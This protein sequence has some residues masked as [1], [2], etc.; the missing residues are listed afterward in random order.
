MGNVENA[1]E[2]LKKY[3]QEHVIEIMNSFTE[4]EKEAISEQILDMNFDTIKSLYDE[5]S[6]DDS[7]FGNNIEPIH[8]LRK[9]KISEEELEKITNLGEDIIKSGKFAVATM[10]GGQGTRLGYNHPKGTFKIDVEPSPKYLFEI[11]CD[12]LKRANK[13]YGVIIPWYIMTS[14]DNNDEIIEFFEEQ[15]YFGYPKESIKFFKQGQMPL[16]SEDGKLLVGENKLI[17]E[18]S[19]G[20]GGIFS[21]MAK[22]GC[23]ADMEKKGVKWL[24]IGSIDNVLLKMADPC[25]IGLA[26]ERG[27]KIATKSVVKNSPTERVGVICKQDGKVGVMEYSEIPKEYSEAVDEDGELVYGESHIMCNLFNMDI[28]KELADKKLAYHKAH[29][30]NSFIDK[31]GN[32]IKPEEPNSY[33]FEMF[34]FDSF[35]YVN[36]IAILRGKR[37]VDFAP[38]KNK[39]GNDS[40]ETARELYNNYWK[41]VRGE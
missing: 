3:N 23:L 31:N 5:L 35:E 27:V 29:K 40:P 36:D 33:K 10:S 15:N 38:V 22:S 14:E 19:D 37:E 39:E 12:T 32:V 8:A 1:I 18:A 41:N 21:S 7:K 9:E 13:K 2:K 30:K 11:V 20:N 16:I 25:L 34:I 6:K 24:F 28:L 4:E 17:K 26:E